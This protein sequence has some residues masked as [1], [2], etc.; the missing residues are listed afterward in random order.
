LTKNAQ[1]AAALQ[2]RALV[3]TIC[4]CLQRIPGSDS[5]QVRVDVLD[6][7]PGVRSDLKT[8]IFER[9]FSTRGVLGRGRGLANVREILRKHG[10]T[11]EEVGQLGDQGAHF[12]LWFPALP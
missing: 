5:A 12:V 10:G 1:E 2:V 8:R 6:N 11:I 9:R 7:G 4:A 3:M